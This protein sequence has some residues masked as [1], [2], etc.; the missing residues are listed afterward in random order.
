[1]HLERN[2]LPPASSILTMRLLNGRSPN[3]MSFDRNLEGRHEKRLPI[4]VVVQLAD[5]EHRQ[6]AE[7]EKTYADNVSPHGACVA[8]GRPWQPGEELEVTSNDVTARAKVVYCRRTKNGRYFV[9]LTFPD[10]PIHWSNFSFAF[11]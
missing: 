2:L 11:H 10:H 9:G 4:V 3:T 8:S 6:T 1:M 5:P 7:E